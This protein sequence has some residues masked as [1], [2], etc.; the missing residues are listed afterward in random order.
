MLSKNKK[1]LDHPTRIFK[2]R[3]NN[4]LKNPPYDRK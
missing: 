4:Y 1:K 2:I 3:K